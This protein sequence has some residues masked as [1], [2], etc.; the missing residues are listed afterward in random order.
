[1]HTYYILPPI[2]SLLPSESA[3]GAS[4]LAL[5][6]GAAASLGLGF[7][8]NGPKAVTQPHTLSTEPP[9]RTDTQS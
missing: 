6:V 1:M 3:Q 5:T 9:H 4:H 7:A 8:A 2:C